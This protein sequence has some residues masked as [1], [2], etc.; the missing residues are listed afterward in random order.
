VPEIGDFGLAWV[1]AGLLLRRG[2]HEKEAAPKGRSRLT[3]VPRA[4]GLA[5]L[6][7]G[8]WTAR[9]APAFLCGW[10]A[11]QPTTW[12]DTLRSSGLLRVQGLGLRRQ[13]LSIAT[14]WLDRA[15]TT[16]LTSG[17]TL[18]ATGRRQRPF[19][20]GTSMGF[21]SITSSTRRWRD[22]LWDLNFARVAAGSRPCETKTIIHFSPSPLVGLLFPVSRPTVRRLRQSPA[23]VRL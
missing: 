16:S 20:M 13:D 15:T 12:C 11:T 3:A 9:R 19:A 22:T 18:P 23:A 5:L 7:F 4:H 17:A 14:S 2:R 1:L 21:D 8:R 10:R 6:P